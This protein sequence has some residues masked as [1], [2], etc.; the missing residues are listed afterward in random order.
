MRILE[1]VSRSPCLLHC[2]VLYVSPSRR[3][4]LVAIRAAAWE[5]RYAWN[6][7]DR[8]DVRVCEH[9]RCYDHIDAEQS[10]LTQCLI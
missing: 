3:V 9:C 1:S 6:C 8:D 2:P 5:G 4:C 10:A 7:T